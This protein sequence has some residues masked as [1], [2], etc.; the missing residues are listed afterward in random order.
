MGKGSKLHLLGNVATAQHLIYRYTLD[1]VFIEA[2]AWTTNDIE[3]SEDCYIRILIRYSNDKTITEAIKSELVN[4]EI[5]IRIA[6]QIVTNKVYEYTLNERVVPSYFREQLESALTKAEANMIDVGID[7]ETFIFL[8]DL[9]WEDNSKNSPILVETIANKLPI[10]TAVLCGDYFNG[11]AYAP[12]IELLQDCANQFSK[13]IKKPVF[14]FG[15]H[16]SNELSPNT[17]VE[18]DPFVKAEFYAVMQKYS[19][20]N[21][22]YGAY[23][24]FYFDNHA[25]RTR[26]ICLDTLMYGDG[27]HP[28]QQM[29][30]ETTL[31]TMLDGYRALVFAHIIY[32]AKT[33]PPSES[34]PW[35]LT[36]FMNTICEMCDTFN[37]NNTNGNEV[38]ALFGGHC[39][40]DANLTTTGGIPIILIDCD[41]RKTGS[42]VGHAVGTINEQCLDV[43]TIDY[44]NRNIKCVRVG[45]GSDRTITY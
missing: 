10:N 44:K 37:T 20:D 36:S 27:L 43:V 18:V 2:G 42:A 39:H 38:I 3:I 16:D 22:T 40:I 7:G 12:M 28:E 26:Y 41:A 32:P 24:Y 17:G 33:T 45:R 15:N 8:S 4:N 31:N 14:L 29:W 11:G 21:V 34:N 6:P 5:F 19:E 9:H 30:F 25:T 23:N 35:T 13:S 1:K